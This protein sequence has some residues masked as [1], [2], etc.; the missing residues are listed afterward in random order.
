[1]FVFKHKESDGITQ[2]WYSLIVTLF[3]ICQQQ[4]TP[5]TLLTRKQINQTKKRPPRKRPSQII[6]SGLHSHK[7]PVA[8]WQ[9]SINLTNWKLS[10]SSKGSSVFWSSEKL[11]HHYWQR[12][13]WQ[14]V[15]GCHFQGNNKC[16]CECFFKMLD[17]YSWMPSDRTSLKTR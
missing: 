9:K 4:S 3:W 10:P 17:F 5:Q 12:R 6:S 2:L 1:M 13:Y 8:T 7:Q 16:R 15:R 11:K 14:M